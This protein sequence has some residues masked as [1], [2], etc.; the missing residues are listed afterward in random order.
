MDEKQ[1]VCETG[2]CGESCG[3]DA[4]SRGELCCQIVPFA[5][6]TLIIPDRQWS[7]AESRGESALFRKDQNVLAG[8]EAKKPLASI[9]LEASGFDSVS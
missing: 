2:V 9:V 1:S 6:F 8:C 4:L 3:Q 5:L 7:A